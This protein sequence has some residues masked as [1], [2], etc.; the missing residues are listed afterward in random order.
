M[1]SA[2]GR[3]ANSSTNGKR[4]ANGARS[5]GQSTFVSVLSSPTTPIDATAEIAKNA[6]GRRN[7]LQSRST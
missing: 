3:S 7:A 4:P 2:S 5:H 6:A 1:R